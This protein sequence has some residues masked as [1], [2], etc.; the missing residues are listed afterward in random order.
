MESVFSKEEISLLLNFSQ[1][2][3][4][5]LPEVFQNILKGEFKTILNT[6]TDTLNLNQFSDLNID[7][8]PHL[9][10]G[11]GIASFLYFVQVNWVGPFVEEEIQCMV[12]L[13]ETAIQHLSLDDQLNE[14]VK[15]PE[16]LFVSKS[17]F[18]ISKLQSVLPST[19]W[20]LMRANCI[21]QQILD[22]DSVILFNETETLLKS[23]SEKLIN[24]TEILRVLFYLESAQFYLSYRRI[25]RSQD[26][27]ERAKDL[28]KMTIELGGALGKRTKYQQNEKAQLYLDVK[29][30]KDIFSFRSC[31]D[32]PKSVHLNDDLRLD[33]VQFNTAVEISEFGSIEEAVTLCS[34]YHAKISQP[35][36]EITDEELNSYLQVLI[37]KSTNYSL[38]MSSLFQRCILES[39]HKRTIERSLVQMEYLI[40]KSKNDTVPLSLRLDLFFASGM[41][42]HWI[43]RQNLANIMLN[44]GM[45]K[46]ALEIYLELKLWEDVIVCYTILD[47]KGRAT[48]IIQQ[49]LAKKPSVKLYCLLGDATESVEHYEKAWEFSGK[50]SS[51]AQKHWGLHYFGKQNYKEAIPHLQ[52]SAELNG[53]QEQIWAR[54]GYAALQVE[55]WKLAASAY[56]K[57]CSLEQSSFEIWNNLANAYIKM[58]EKSKAHK[59]LQDAIK[60]NYENWKVWDN[61]M[62][63]STDLGLFS[64]VLLSY[65]RILD[66]KQ[67]GHVDA[68]VLTILCDAI[69]NTSA[70]KYLNEAL[71]LFGHLTAKVLTNSDVWR[72]YGDLTLVKEDDIS[73][74]KAMQYFQKAH[75]ILVSDAKWARDEKNIARVLEICLKM[76]KTIDKSLVLSK[77]KDILGSAKLSIQ[78]VLKKIKDEDIPLKEDILKDSSEVSKCLESLIQKLENLKLQT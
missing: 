48:E 49:E 1:K 52:L 4:L 31:K 47:M 71:K 62:V 58:G 41:K 56:K 15:Y 72:L 74:Q 11:L 70:R 35:K 75:K 76:A 26:F 63:V 33:S 59:C 54:L 30:K 12:S 57:Y 37:D 64:D 43:F 44:V 16:L 8:S 78:S 25:Y 60:C 13:R 40:E 14:N 20:W 66:L 69:I 39:H 29:I 18:L 36:D 23:L 46:G 10:L 3:D 53:I 27:I 68:Q 2:T 5:A 61:F 77:K 51:K 19:T 67:E 21:H 42:P 22:E 9:L 24:S 55:D 6:K 17:I 34:F 32:L 28:C 50:K 65:H 73:E 7:D 45:V 38:K